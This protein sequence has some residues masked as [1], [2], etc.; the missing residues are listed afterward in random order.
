[1]S[2]DKP[3]PCPECGGPLLS[4]EGKVVARHLAQCKVMI[5]DLLKRRGPI[6]YR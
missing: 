4:P 1:M 3:K 6:E 2:A 5:A